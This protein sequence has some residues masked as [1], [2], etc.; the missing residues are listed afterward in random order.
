MTTIRKQYGAKFKARVAIR[1]IRVAARDDLQ[2]EPRVKADD[3]PA[4]VPPRLSPGPLNSPAG[5]LQD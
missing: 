1:A 4:F 2:P 3:K 5:P